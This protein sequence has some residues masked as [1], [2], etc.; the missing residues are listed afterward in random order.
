M[1]SCLF[2][3]LLLSHCTLTCP[4][5]TPFTHKWNKEHT[6]Y[7]QLPSSCWRQGIDHAWANQESR[8]WAQGCTLILP[9]A[10]AARRGAVLHPCPGHWLNLFQHWD[11]HSEAI[12]MWINHLFLLPDDHLHKRGL[13]YFQKQNLLISKAPFTMT[14]HSGP[15]VSFSGRPNQTIHCSLWSSGCQRTCVH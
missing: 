15:P 3:Q 1:T 6:V 10:L 9:H 13:T 7:V 4:L 12:Q 5:S 8:E 2:W 14:D 11:G